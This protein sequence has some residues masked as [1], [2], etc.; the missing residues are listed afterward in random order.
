M[1]LIITF[2][3]RFKTLCQKIIEWVNI[4]YHFMIFFQ[5][6]TTYRVI[7]ATFNNISVISRR[8][9]LLM[10]ETTYLPQVADKLYHIM[11]HRVHLTWAQFELTLLVIGTDCIGSYKSNYHTFMTTTTTVNYRVQWN[12]SYLF[13]YCKTFL[14]REIVR[15]QVTSLIMSHHNSVPVPIQYQDI[16]RAHHT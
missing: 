1:H 6:W 4:V 2:K 5:I 13:D 12:A 10:E 11:L 15:I 16:H 9:V 7:N 14:P 8:S 3:N